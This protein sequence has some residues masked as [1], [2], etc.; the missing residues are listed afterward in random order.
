MKIIVPDRQI[1]HPQIAMAMIG[2]APVDYLNDPKLGRQIGIGHPQLDQLFSVLLNRTDAMARE[3]VAL[4]ER[5]SALD[6]QAIPM[7]PGQD[8]AGPPLVPAPE[9][10]DPFAAAVAAAA[11][12]G[13]NAAPQNGTARG[14][15]C[16]PGDQDAA[17]GPDDDDPDDVA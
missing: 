13:P 17:Q 2:G 8:Q 7:V 11:K 3:I 10:D 4:R 1:A 12:G 16:R 14:P 5:L 9:P 6:S 15:R